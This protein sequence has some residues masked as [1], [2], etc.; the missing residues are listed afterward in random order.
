MNSLNQRV[1]RSFHVRHKQPLLGDKIYFCQN[2]HIHYVNE[3]YD[4]WAH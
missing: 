2:V 1:L 4:L 3:L